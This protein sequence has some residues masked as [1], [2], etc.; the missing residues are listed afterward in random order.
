MTKTVLELNGVSKIFPNG[1]KV[2]SVLSDI[3]MH[4]QEGEFVS[5]IGPSGSGKSTLFRLIGG[6]E[7][8]TA[9]EIRIEG[10]LVRGERGRVAYMPQQ[11]SLMPWL[12]VSRNIE[13]ALEIAGMERKQ[14][15]QLALEWLERIGL[16]GERDAYP[17]TL[18][19]GM[20]QRI[21]FLRALLSPQQLM[22]LDEPFGALDALTRLH[23][24]TWLLSLWE[25]DR[26]SVLFVTHSIEEALLLSDRILVLSAAPATVVREIKV[27]FARPRS[28]ELWK[29]PL[30]NELKLDIYSLLS[31]VQ[32]P[33][34]MK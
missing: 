31:P 6:L 5:L 18:S 15:R 25:A 24:Q 23:M 21:S 2:K 32:S 11:A 33:D 27:P 19:G 34:P 17:H 3:S 28:E 12:S 22:L 29:D 9:G 16:A 1:K 8:P 14:A 10:G 13:L 30:F 4:V 7:K 20:Q 26:R